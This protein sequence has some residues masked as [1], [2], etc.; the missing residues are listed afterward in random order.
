MNHIFD[1]NFARLLRIWSTR[2][3]ASTPMSTIRYFNQIA[4]APS[5]D[6]YSSINIQPG[7]QKLCGDNQADTGALAFVRFRHTDTDIVR[8]RASAGLHPLGQGPVSD[9]RPGHER[10]ARLTSSAQHVQTDHSLHTTD[11]MINL[12]DVMINARS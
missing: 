8:E 5:P 4:A 6:N 7:Y 9:Q 11:G 10:Q 1:V 12:F 3:D 2:S